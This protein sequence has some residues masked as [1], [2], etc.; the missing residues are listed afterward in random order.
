M[1]VKIAFPEIPTGAVLDAAT[2]TV[3]DRL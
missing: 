3:G 2:M 1:P